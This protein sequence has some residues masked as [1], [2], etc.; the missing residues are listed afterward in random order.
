MNAFVHI[1]L[2]D[3]VLIDIEENKI[4]C[5][6]CERVYYKGT[7]IDHEQGIRIEPFVPSDG[8]CHDC[9]SHEFATGSDPASFEKRLS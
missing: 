4:K 3:N 5:Q 9:G 6:S 2:P 8:H 1:S 7:I